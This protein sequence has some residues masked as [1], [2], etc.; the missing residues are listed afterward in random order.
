MNQ[1]FLNKSMSEYLEKSKI[2]G[3]EVTSEAGRQLFVLDVEDA[4]STK[5]VPIRLKICF[6]ADRAYALKK[7][8][9][10]RTDISEKPRLVLEVEKFKE[11]EPGVFFPTEACEELFRGGRGEPVVTLN[12]CRLVV[13]QVEVNVNLPPETFKFDFPVGTE[14]YD[15]FLGTGYQT[16]ATKQHLDLIEELLVGERGLGKGRSENHTTLRG[17]ISSSSVTDADQNSFERK[18]APAEMVS[19][20]P[21][22]EENKPLAVL[23]HWYFW[24]SFLATLLVSLYVI[25]KVVRRTYRSRTGGA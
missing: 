9:F 15:Q 2:H 17:I 24:A 16:G 4:T 7:V 13:E 10:F 23:G 11:I 21:Q 12:S 14:V 25:A 18:Q 6:D 19:P 20:A 5:E 8:E 1:S 3:V 22:V